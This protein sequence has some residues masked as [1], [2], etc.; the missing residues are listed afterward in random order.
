[1]E[2]RFYKN[3]MSLLCNISMLYW[4]KKGEIFLK[5]IKYSEAENCVQLCT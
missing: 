5:K 1:M 4:Q 3:I 2:Y